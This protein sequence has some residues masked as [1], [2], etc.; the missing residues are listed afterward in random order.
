MYKTID[1]NQI[2]LEVET[3]VQRCREFFSSS[4]QSEKGKKKK[5][6]RNF[7]KVNFRQEDVSFSVCHVKSFAFVLLILMGLIDNIITFGFL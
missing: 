1:R 3:K 5:I 4:V 6:V 7:L 2:F